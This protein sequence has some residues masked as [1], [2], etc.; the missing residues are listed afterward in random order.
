M[1]NP[2]SFQ[3]DILPLFTE[4]DIHAMSKAFSLASYEDV[5]KHAAA[6]ST[7]VSAASVVRSCR[8]LRQEGRAPG[9]KSTLS[10]LLSGWRTDTNLRLLQ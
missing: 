10:S 8:R 4:R 5:K 9:L 3:S 2:T 1:A 7:T 6:T